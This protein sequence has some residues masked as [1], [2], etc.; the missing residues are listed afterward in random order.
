[1]VAAESTSDKLVPRVVYVTV[2]GRLFLC[3]PE[4]L[5]PVSL[6]AEWVQ[7][8]LKSMDMAQQQTFQ[9]MRVARG[10]DV[11]AERPTSAE[12]EAAYEEPEAIIRV[13]E[14][15]AEA[16]YEPNPQGPPT[17]APGTP[18]PGTPTLASRTAAPAVV[19]SLEVPISLPAPVGGEVEIGAELD[20][21]RG[22]KRSHDEMGEVEAMSRDRA[23][24][25]PV[26]QD[27]LQSP[28]P[29]HAVD[30]VRHGSESSGAR[31]RS[32]TPSRN[33]PP[34]E[35]SFWAYSD[36]QGQGSDHV[37]EGWYTSS[38]EHDYNGTS[39]G[40]EFDID[41]E[42]IRD[43]ESILF[44]IREM[45]FSAAAAQKR[46]VEVS[47]RSLDAT[48]R[49]MFREAK[50]A[51]WSQWVNNDVIELISR[52]GI[53]PKR[54]ISSRWVLTWKRV[55]ETPDS[56]RKPKA[57]LVIRGFRDPDL[58]QFS[59]ASP[60]LSRQGRHAI[61]TLA[62]HFQFR[63]FTLDAKTV[64]LA[65]DQSSRTKPIY[66]ELPKDLVSDLDLGPETI[67]RIKKVPYGLSEAPLAWYKRLTTE[68]VKCG[69]QQVAADRWVL[70][71]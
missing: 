6:K 9:D 29:S 23:E 12:L 60:T 54:V 22:G 24:H 65:G 30:T 21:K 8:Q 10:T 13:E 32:R 36:F 7:N 52:R 18:I 51:E 53:D 16:D 62:A 47:E 44:I 39:I 55:D 43:E 70:S 57:R 35:G 33:P 20:T 69:F 71:T 3:S 28:P 26:T 49:Q 50:R 4:Q 40:L 25:G 42:E 56:A 48:E 67:A 17:P 34:R 63:I 1:M 11:R 15:G 41:L 61:L 46:R 14:L 59:T 58:G 27:S 38:R 45:C 5:R 37:E 2:H 64:F 31:A 68:L 66:A 19:P